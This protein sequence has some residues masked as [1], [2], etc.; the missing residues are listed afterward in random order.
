VP[1]AVAVAVGLVAIFAIARA[2][3]PV[4]M[5]RA[6]LLIPAAGLTVGGLAI[7]FA[8][9]TDKPS[10]EVLFSGQ[11]QLPGLIDGAGTWSQ[12]AL[13]LVL[14]CKGLAWS[15]S[16][17]GYRGGPTFPGLYLGGAAGVLASHLPGF[18]LTPAVAVGM[19]AAVVAVLRLPIAAVL[20]STL[21]CAKAGTGAE[22][23]I[24]VGVV[25]ALITARV[26]DAR[27]PFDDGARHPMRV[28]PGARAAPTVVP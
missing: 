5:R 23:L 9:M 19:G 10:S 1:L 15:A 12:T 24:I 6:F 17:A 21:L 27:T 7:A 20:L 18:A 13:G 3:Q 28:T 14:L 22:P 4:L 11:D 16:L 2:V 25:A 26:A 8:A